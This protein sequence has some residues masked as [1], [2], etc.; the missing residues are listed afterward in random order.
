[1]NKDKIEIN[2]NMAEELVISD[3]KKRWMLSKYPDL[4]VKHIWNWIVWTFREWNIK[5]YDK[6]INWEVD[7]IFNIAGVRKAHY[8]KKALYLAWFNEIKDTNWIY[9]LYKRKDIDS[10]NW[11]PIPWSKPLDKYSMEY[12]NAWNNIVFQ[13]DKLGLETMKN[14]DTSW[15]M[16]HFSEWQLEWYIESW[17]P[18]IKDL[19]TFLKQKQIDKKTFDKHFPSVQKLLLSQIWDTRFEALWDYV[20]EQEIKDYYEWGYIPKELARECYK[21]IKERDS[22]KQK[23][24]KKKKE[25]HSKASHDINEIHQA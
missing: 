16:H 12:F 1:M 24:E 22:L 20:T 5:V 14:A 17:V 2:S 23:K 8:F 10:K 3:L 4:K 25:I 18:R 19:H 6:I 13:E 7:V 21:K 11:N 15:N 9:N